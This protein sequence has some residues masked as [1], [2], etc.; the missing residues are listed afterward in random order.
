[1]CLRRRGTPEAPG[2]V[3]TLVKSRKIVDCGERVVRTVVR[4]VQMVTADDD[5]V[6]GVVYHIAGEHEVEVLHQ[7]Y[8]R[9]KVCFVYRACGQWFGLTFP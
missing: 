3:V 4:S 8:Y 7:L 9:E 1:V 5:E 6:F 2:R